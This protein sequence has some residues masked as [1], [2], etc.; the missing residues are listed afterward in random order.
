MGFG[1]LW[2]NIEGSPILDG[3]KELLVLL[4]KQGEA[5]VSDQGANNAVLGLLT[6]FIVLRVAFEKIVEGS[7]L[8]AMKEDWNAPFPPGRRS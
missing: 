4:R 7:S 1:N 6:P 2:G 8:D 3:P 5:G